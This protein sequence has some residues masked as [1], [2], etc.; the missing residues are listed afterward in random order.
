MLG[1][2]SGS[3]NTMEKIK[4]AQDKTLKKKKRIRV[5]KR[6]EKIQAAEW[7]GEELRDNIRKRSKLSRRWR[8]ARK[9][10][11]PEQD[12]KRFEKEYKEQNT[13]TAIMTGQKKGSWELFKI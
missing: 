5:G 7:V 2:K 1:K 12:V 6:E 13:I 9:R 11:E 4:I 10:K 3:H 8:M